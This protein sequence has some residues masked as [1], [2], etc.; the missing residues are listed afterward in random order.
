V[1]EVHAGVQAGKTYN[2][3]IMSVFNGLAKPNYP[4]IAKGGPGSGPHALYNDILS[5]QRSKEG[6]VAAVRH[7][8]TG[9]VH[10]AQQ[11]EAHT[12]IL[13]RIEGDARDYDQGFVTRNG[14]FVS[15]NTAE[16][17]FQTLARK[18]MVGSLDLIN[19]SA[20]DY[21]AAEIPELILEI[22]QDQ[23]EAVQAILLDGIH[24]G[25]DGPQIA[26][27]IRDSVGLTE[28]QA[29]WVINFRNQLESGEE[30]P[31]TPV[32]DRRLSAIDSAAAQAEMN[33]EETDPD[34]VDMLV[35][36]YGFSLLN[37][38]AMDIAVSELHSAMIQGQDDLWHQAKDLGYL[39]PA[40]TRRHWLGVH[41]SK[42]REDHWATEDMNEPDGVGLDEPFD[43]PV[44]PVMNPGDSGVDEFDI[45]DRCTVYLT[46]NDEFGTGGESDQQAEEEGIGE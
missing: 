43:T 7:L 11:G 13:N 40:I 38:R 46:F 36:K 16:H 22:N 42:E 9:E 29:Q 26:R 35:E 19:P 6:M 1:A 21:L 17:S 10:P 33:S 45:N 14:N 18:A 15:R 24:G 5:R 39:D 3:K 32:G 8:D 44:G 4:H 34:A 31:Y 37:K 25:K 20:V 41:D 12:D 2:S 30:G 23:A 28:Q 27:E